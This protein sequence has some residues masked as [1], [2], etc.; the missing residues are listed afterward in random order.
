[1]FVVHISNCHGQ[2]CTRRAI[3]RLGIDNILIVSFFFLRQAHKSM[4]IN[5]KLAS[6]P[7]CAY[8][9][10]SY[11]KHLFLLFRPKSIFCAFPTINRVKVKL[12]CEFDV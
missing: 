6:E 2:N 9:I 7:Q 8:S 3:Y 4:M 1:M 11:H 5:K 10:F 12:Y